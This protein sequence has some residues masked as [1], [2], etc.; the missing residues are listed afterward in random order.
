MSPRFLN[1]GRSLLECG[2]LGVAVFLSGCSKSKDTTRSAAAPGTTA[3]PVVS[4][5][6]RELFAA[7]NAGEIEARLRRT[8]RSLGTFI[9]LGTAS[10]SWIKREFALQIENRSQKNFSISCPRHL[11]ATMT[12]WK[13]PHESEA[14]TPEFFYFILLPSNFEVTVEAGKDA[15]PAIQGVWYLGNANRLPPQAEKGNSTLFEIKPAPADSPF[16]RL[17]T[18]L[19]AEQVPLKEEENQGK[20]ANAPEIKTNQWVNLAFIM[21]GASTPPEVVRDAIARNPYVG[22]VRL[23]KTF[24]AL[25]HEAAADPSFDEAE[26]RHEQMMASLRQGVELKDASVTAPLLEK[27]GLSFSQ[28]DAEIAG[29][30]AQL[31]QPRNPSDGESTLP[32]VIEQLG[33]RDLAVL[34]SLFQFALK[35]GNEYGRMKAAVTAVRMGDPRCVPLLAQYLSHPEK[36]DSDVGRVIQSCNEALKKFWE[37]RGHKPGQLQWAEQVKQLGGPDSPD[38]KGAS[39]ADIE[40]L[41]GFLAS[42]KNLRQ[43]AFD[44]LCSDALQHT[45]PE[46]RRRALD[47]LARNQAYNANPKALEVHLTIIKGETEKGLR[48]EAISNLGQFKNPPEAEAPLL[49]C[50]KS[51][52]GVDLESGGDNLNADRNL[53]GITMTVL[54]NMKSKAAIPVLLP[55]L[56]GGKRQ[57]QRASETL[58]EITKLHPK[59]K[60]RAGWDAALSEAKLP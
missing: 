21:T 57:A 24:Q 28:G 40:A 7:M 50:L 31:L 5:E 36:E 8:D 11:L 35:D 52:Q 41:K 60:T 46:V 56:D 33:V 10:G 49:E 51:Y 45:N 20:A 30:V 43:G 27:G 34:D 14:P 26:K 12:G 29:L 18:Q 44:Q 15:S 4:G 23:R 3:K 47:R 6:K 58:S 25:G 55:F 32:V 53:L 54:G 38:L 19:E 17:A 37:D 42:G 22:T 59:E 9:G 1:V 39:P 13:N 48:Y 16:V 2:L